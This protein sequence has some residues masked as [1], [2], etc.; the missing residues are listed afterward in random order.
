MGHK[1]MIFI[2]Y[3]NFLLTS[4]L[5]EILNK[6]IDAEFKHKVSGKSRLVKYDSI[7]PDW[8]SLGLDLN[9]WNFVGPNSGGV[10]ADFYD[11]I[12]TYK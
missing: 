9:Q 3:F 5:R 1:L 2:F 11:C 10:Q 6:I 8:T 7:W 4:S 12:F